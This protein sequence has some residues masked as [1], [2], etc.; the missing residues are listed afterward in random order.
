[1]HTQFYKIL[2]CLAFTVTVNAQSTVPYNHLQTVSDLY[3]KA[4]EYILAANYTV[5]DESKG[6]QLESYKGVIKKSGENMYYKLGQTET[7]MTNKINFIVNHKQKILVVSNVKQLGSKKTENTININEAINFYKMLNL[8]M[9]YTTTGNNIGV[10]TFS[11]PAKKKLYE[12]H[13]NTRNFQVVKMVN[14]KYQTIDKT[15]SAY[16]ISIEYTETK[17][18]TNEVKSSDFL[19]DEYVTV[20][21]GKFV[22]TSK[23]KSYKLITN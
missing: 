19:I 17:I 20:A 15:V 1:M 18:N 3:A 9:A 2:A 23:Y 22:A 4:E 7:I 11:S 8:T 5:Y 12:L 14:Y 16:K 6:M 21:N 10:F 13:Y